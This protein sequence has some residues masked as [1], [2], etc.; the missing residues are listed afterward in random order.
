MLDC[1]QG[2]AALSFCGR[3][4][5]NDKSSFLKILNVLHKL[6]EQVHVV[7]RPW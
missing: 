7:Q 3:T 6:L 1:Y 5:R 4:P 2:I